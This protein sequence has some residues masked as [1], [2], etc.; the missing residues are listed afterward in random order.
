MKYDGAIPH[1]D[2]KRCHKLQN[3][4]KDVFTFQLDSL[5]FTFEGP[6]ENAMAMPA[7]TAKTP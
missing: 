1:H 2:M 7:A 5:N 6:Q 4:K 3:T